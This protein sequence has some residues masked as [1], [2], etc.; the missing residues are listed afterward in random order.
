MLSIKVQQLDFLPSLRDPW[1]RKKESK[2][3]SFDYSRENKLQ[4]L[5]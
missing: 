4:L 1:G 3:L 2:S 5:L